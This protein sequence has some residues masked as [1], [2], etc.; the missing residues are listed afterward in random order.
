MTSFCWIWLKLNYGGSAKFLT[1]KNLLDVKKLTVRFNTAQGTHKALHEVSFAMERGEALGVVGESGSGKSV[2]ALSIMR[3]IP[4][5]PGRITAGEV[6]FLGSDLLKKSDSEMRN[7]RGSEISMI[8]QE[9]MTSLNPLHTCGKQIMEPMLVHK[10]C[11]K[12]DAR[13]RAIEY[14]EMVGIPSPKQRFREYPHQMSGGMRQ[15]VMIAMALVCGPKLLLADEPTTALDVTIQA[16]I[17][18]LMK[19]LRE[20]IDSGIIMITYDMGIVADICDRVAV[21]YAGQV[22][23][24]GLC[25]DIFKDP[26][27]PFTQGLLIAI[28]R[29]EN[30]KKRLF[31][32][33]GMV[34]DP[35]ETPK[36]CAF[37]PRCGLHM[38]IC[39]EMT[40]EL[41]LVASGREARCWL[42]EGKTILRA[43]AV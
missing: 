15:R 31:S 23:E 18:D 17:L 43:E 19:D 20:K 11:S 21:M 29:I 40:P 35:F 33:D 10:N 39:A 12:G 16:Q 2:T 28:P 24:S 30:E 38:P 9:P 41:R 6:N 7:V 36:G 32:I 34:P 42:H 8:F 25:S 37:Q 27:H 22:I 26:L 1:G 5:P 14:L 3:L 4:D 13:D